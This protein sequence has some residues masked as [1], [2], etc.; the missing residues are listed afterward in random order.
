MNTKVKKQKFQFI[1]NRFIV[2]ILAVVL[3]ILII[4]VVILGIRKSMLTT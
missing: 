2:R 3:I 1:K 4:V